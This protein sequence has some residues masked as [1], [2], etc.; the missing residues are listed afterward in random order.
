[1][2]LRRYS[3]K[4]T[5]SASCQTSKVPISSGFENG[6]FSLRINGR[7]V[8]E[9]PGDTKTEARSVVEVLAWN[10]RIE[11]WVDSCFYFLFYY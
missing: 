3:N 7:V 10:V 2:W 1:M 9:A 5:F 11:A 8:A 6:R 4:F